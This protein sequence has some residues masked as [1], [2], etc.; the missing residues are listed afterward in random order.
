[1]HT[2]QTD[3]A[4][5]L[6]GT[7]AFVVPQFQR[8]YKWKQAQWIELFDDIVDQYESEAV[9]TGNLAANEG[10][11]LGS[12]VLHPTPGPAATL[13]RY[14]VIDGQQRLTTLM[15]IIA[16]LRDRRAAHDP[17]WNPDTYNFQYL[18]NQF[19][20]EDPY[21]LR[22]GDNDRGDFIS[23]VYGDDPSGQIGDAYRW[24][25]RAIDK[26]ELD[27]E[28]KFKKF[29]D[30]ILLR[31]LLVE[32][33]TSEDDNINQIFHT[34]NFAGMKLTAI[35]LIRNY[36]FMQ[37][38][39][40]DASRV[41]AQVWRPM[42]DALGDEASLSKY[43]W[44][45]LV[46]IDPKTTQ[47]DLY[48]PYQSL[49]EAA[50]RSSSG[51]NVGGVVESLLRQYLEE[52]PLF[53]A[54][55]NPWD[56]G[57][58][59]AP[60]IRS[61]L[62]DLSEWGSQTYI[63]LALD[64]LGR[65]SSG[66]NSALEVATSLRFLLSYLV[67][68]GLAGVPT[69]NLNR[70]ISA[71]PRA[72]S[73]KP[74]IADAIASELMAAGKYWPTNRELLDRGRTAPVFLTLQSWQIDFVLRE[75]VSSQESELD[76]DD[77]QLHATQVIPSPLTSQWKRYVSVASID[78][79][80]VLARVNN[81]GNLALVP[82]GRSGFD[83]DEELDVTPHV[84]ERRQNWTPE[85][86][87]ERS[88]RLLELAAQIWPRPVD[89]TANSGSDNDLLPSDFD[90]ATILASIPGDSSVALATISELT[91]EDSDQARSISVRLGYPVVDDRVQGLVGS[92]GLETTELRELS[93]GEVVAAVES[94]GAPGPEARRGE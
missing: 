48:H 57:Q 36:S 47:R 63:P 34:I 94:I 82:S 87:D 61:A 28:D 20:P 1:M 75:L 13:A 62:Q 58:S 38:S 53:E 32:I 39:Q 89:D 66:R 71:I 55:D 65:L 41:Y 37:F 68:R 44:A 51:N 31:L 54:I 42:E 35:D 49:I 88:A 7:K 4:R 90:I 74:K 21:K 93:A 67:R 16:A 50:R 77:A 29:E 8:H 17:T 40:E 10:H 18:Q 85:Y 79:E 70:I 11:F 43:L 23:T 45:Q 76:L 30:A 60:E 24:F 26:L 25:G 52:L 2:R 92:P 78:V 6:M 56:S 81:L 12:I 33:N 14:W 27:S 9:Q 69:N 73:N 80:S 59:L 19:H 84:G 91:G 64:L 83:P 15:V 86:I 46:R 3:L 72:I 5:L 22:P